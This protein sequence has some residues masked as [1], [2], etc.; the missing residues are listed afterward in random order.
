MASNSARRHHVLT[1]DEFLEMEME[2]P[3]RHEFVGGNIYAF[4]GASDAHNRLALKVAARLMHATEGGPC[5]VYMRDMKLQA[6]E[7]AV[8]YPDVLVTCDPEDDGDYVKHSPCLVVEVL[9]PSTAS[10]DQ[11]E[12]LLAYRGIKSVLA[13]VIIDQDTRRATV[14]NRDEQG[15]WWENLV[16]PRGRIKL[17]CPEIELTMDDIYAGINLD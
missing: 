10:V 9:S 1:L 15:T 11:R 12:K 3:V 8:Y 4:A 14:H 13:Y 17:P 16:P 6:S 7:Q 5:R 2:S